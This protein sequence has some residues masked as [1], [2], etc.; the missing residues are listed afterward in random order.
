MVF[1][2][3][4]AATVSLCAAAEKSMIYQGSGLTFEV[5]VPAQFVAKMD[6]LETRELVLK[7]Q[8]IDINAN[9]V[10]EFN[11]QSKNAARTQVVGFEINSNGLP[12]FVIHATREDYRKLE[13]ILRREYTTTLYPAPPGLELALK[14]AHK[15][16]PPA[17]A[18]IPAAP[19][20]TT[21]TKGW[22]IPLD[23]YGNDARDPNHR[24]RSTGQRQVI[25]DEVWDQLTPEMWEAIT[26]GYDPFNKDA[27]NYINLNAK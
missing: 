25:P 22:F 3:V 10:F 19:A 8:G 14:N 9:P 15:S 17:M 12:R 24:I 23:A 26:N 2:V 13:L 6:D 4:F 20:P 1:A 16:P 21:G 11:W 27:P 18:A 7:A 5:H